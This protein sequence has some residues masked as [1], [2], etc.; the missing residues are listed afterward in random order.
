MTWL[1]PLEPRSVG[2][3]SSLIS[4]GV[5]EEIIDRHQPAPV[6]TTSSSLSLSHYP[7]LSLLVITQTRRSRP[8]GASV[9]MVSLLHLNVDIL[10]PLPPRN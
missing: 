1:W 7:P 4:R 6:T 5:E 2:Q 9:A 8:V 3:I 10:A